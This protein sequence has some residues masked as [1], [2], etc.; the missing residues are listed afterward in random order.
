[1]AYSK[2]QRPVQHDLLSV[3]F[4]H[5]R[6]PAGA[7]IALAPPNTPAMVLVEKS[8]AVSPLIAGPN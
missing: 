2:S 1:M 8:G 4:S 6:A 7:T 5:P 3:L